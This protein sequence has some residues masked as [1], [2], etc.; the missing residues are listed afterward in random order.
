[1]HLYRDITFMKILPLH[2]LNKVT[3]LNHL[4]STDNAP[5]G[6][7]ETPHWTQTLEYLHQVHAL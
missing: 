4:T 1:M 7:H 5:P 6:D 2:K 3:P